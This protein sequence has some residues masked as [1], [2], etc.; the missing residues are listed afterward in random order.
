MSGSG[1]SYTGPNSGGF[2]GGGSGGGMDCGSLSFDTFIASPTPEALQ[3]NKDDILC[4][5]LEYQKNMALVLV[6]QNT[7]TMGGI[8]SSYLTQLRECMENG[9]NYSARVISVDSG[10]V[11]IFVYPAE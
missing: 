4:L 6:K 2:G 7:V 5:S 9:N 8:A 10:K 3:L 11:K 1:S